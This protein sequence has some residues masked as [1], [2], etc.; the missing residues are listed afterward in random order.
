VHIFVFSKRVYNIGMTET[1]DTK[2]I[3]KEVAAGKAY[4]LDVRSKEEFAE[5]SLPNSINL[6]VEDIQ[7]GKV[8]DLPRNSKIYTYCVTGARSEKATSL[9]KMMDFTN[10]INAGGIISLV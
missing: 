7:Y 3:H 2:K 9:L 8:P 4:L 1:I 5:F 6:S 10:V